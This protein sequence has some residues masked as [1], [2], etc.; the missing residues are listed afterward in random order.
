MNFKLII[1][2]FTKVIALEKEQ[3]QLHFLMGSQSKILKAM[4]RCYH[5]KVRSSSSYK[6][7]GASEVRLIGMTKVTGASDLV[8]H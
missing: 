8:T 2:T 6:T 4:G 1:K 7:I 3:P 5:Q